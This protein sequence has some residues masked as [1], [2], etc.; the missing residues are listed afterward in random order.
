MTLFAVYF[1]IQIV[2]RIWDV[3]L[4]EGRK[5]IFRIALAI[6]KLCEKALLAGELEHFF[7]ILKEFKDKITVDVL[8]NTAFKFT[9]SKALIDQYDRE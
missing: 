5:T 6:L 4:L 7:M 3:Y 8:L 1:P 9:F 2:V